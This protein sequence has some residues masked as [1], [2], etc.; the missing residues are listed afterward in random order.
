MLS[1]VAPDKMPI[2]LENVRSVLKVRTP[3][4]LLLRSCH[5]GLVV[6]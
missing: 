2:V 1:A 6:N 3:Y 5:N 4:L